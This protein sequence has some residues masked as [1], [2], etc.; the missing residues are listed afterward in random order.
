M[1]RWY[2]WMGFGLVILIV[3]LI[4]VR[5]VMAENTHNNR[6]QPSAVALTPT[7]PSAISVES[8]QKELF[9][10]RLDVTSR[11]SLMEKIDLQKKADADREAGV[12]NP[13]PKDAAGTLPQ[14]SKAM[15]QVEDSSG[16]YPGSDA[17]VKPD[18]AQIN[19]YWQGKIGDLDVVVLAGSDPNDASQ[20][21]VL[22]ITSGSGEQKGSYERFL[23]P[24]KGGSLRITGVNGS[25]IVMQPLNGGQIAFD[26]NQKAFIQ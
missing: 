4:A 6:V 11:E 1:K 12:S 14:A 20:G 22:M 16:I 5:W 25:E 19:N 10:P 18:E 26:I 3:S 15:A 9:D 8:M 7:P 23:T 24:V 21:L 2:P 17:M 13:A